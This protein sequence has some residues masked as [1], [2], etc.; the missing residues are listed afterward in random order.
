[1]SIPTREHDGQWT[2]FQHWVNYASRDIGGTNAVCYD[3]KDRLCLIGRDFMLAESDGAFPVR[4]WWGEG[5]ETKAQQRK[6]QSL[7]RQVDKLNHPWRY[8]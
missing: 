3:A 7:A 6:S 4:Y 5:S 2:T 1:M 8:R